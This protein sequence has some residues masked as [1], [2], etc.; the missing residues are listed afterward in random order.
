[1]HDI[2][3]ASALLHCF[4]DIVAAKRREG[5]V[6]VAV[7]ISRGDKGNLFVLE[8]AAPLSN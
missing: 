7:Q 6:L 4:D 3:S 1:M 2:S 8:K 5:W